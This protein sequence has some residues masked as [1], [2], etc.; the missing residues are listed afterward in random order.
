M[1]GVRCLALS[2]MPLAASAKS[3]LVFGPHEDDE[4]F[5]AA[6]VTKRATIRMTP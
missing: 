2:V 4:I 3:I 5:L 1:A 6:G